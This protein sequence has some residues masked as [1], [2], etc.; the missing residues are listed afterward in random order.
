MD[1]RIV[2]VC[3]ACGSD[4]L[5]KY[6]DLGIVPLCNS[7]LDHEL[8]E[9]KSYPI[10]VL[11]C[12]ECHLSQLSIV[13]NPEIMFSNYLYHSSVSK[14]FQDHCYGMAVTLKNDFKTCDHPLVL[15]IASNDGCLLSQFREAGFL[16]LL[17][18]DPAKNFSNPYE[19]EDDFYRGYQSIN[20]FWSEDL[21]KRYK[22]VSTQ[23]ASFIIAQNVFG[24][25]DDL[26]DFLKGV[27]WFLDP[28][29]V[30]VVEVPH[31]YNLIKNNQFDTIYH[32]HLSYFLLKPLKLLFKK[33]GLPIFR[34]EEYNIHGGSL[35]I[36]AS[37]DVYPEEQSVRDME[38]FEDVNGMYSVQTYTHF[39]ERVE[40]I[41][42][43]FS[44]M[45]ELLYRTGSKVMGYGASA[46]GISLI[47]YCGFKPEYIHSIVDDTPQKQ[48][49]LTPGSLIPIVDSS[50]FKTTPPN[51]VILLAWNFA[52]ELMSKH[53]EFK[54][55]WIVPIPDIK[56]I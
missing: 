16:R 45:L 40:V 11:L 4:K 54:G 18:V 56:I 30:F 29:G 21:A 44:L 36:Y 31:L 1:Y 42:S 33:H 7:L 46:K 52:K 37:K 48:G 49:K 22:D 2:K 3:R 50:A 6:L 47:N 15:D 38:Y 8:Q 19:D 5:I 51:F 9:S 24:H 23:G 28:N 12:N 20:A 53:P 17:G 41:K 10:Q 27:H 34:V 13:V 26:N 39:A 35:R 43:K 25:V 55:T 32:E 14:T